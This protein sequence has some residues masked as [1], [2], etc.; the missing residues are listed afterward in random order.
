MTRLADHAARFRALS[1]LDSTLLVE[2]AAGTGKTALMASRLTMM[3]A[4]CLSRCNR[5][6]LTG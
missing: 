4:G 1:E 3:L 6:F 5:L 2:A